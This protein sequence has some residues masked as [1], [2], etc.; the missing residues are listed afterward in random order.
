MND[1][2][3]VLEIID[4]NLY[5]K[6]KKLVDEL[7]D[8]VYPNINESLAVDYGIYTNHN[9]E[10]FDLVIEQAGHILKV[11]EILQIVYKENDIEK[12]NTEER[13]KFFFLNSLELFILLCAI[14]VHDIGLIIDRE[15]HATNILYTMSILK[16]DNIS[17]VVKQVISKIA[18]AHT[19]SKEGE[20]DTIKI[21]DKMIAIKNQYVRPQTLAAILRFS[22]ELEEGEHRTSLTNII[23]G[24]IKD[25]NIVFHKYSLSLIDLSINHNEYCLTLQ[26]E[27]EEKENKIYKKPNG[28]EVKL[29]EE[30]YN[31]LQKLEVER[32]YFHRFMCNSLSIEKI[33]SK[34][35]F[36]DEYGN[37]N[38]EILVTTMDTYPSVE[39]HGLE[40]LKKEIEAMQ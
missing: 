12:L 39:S 36:K 7:E 3:K 10:H 23:T 16:I 38:K 11:K 14:R 33:H 37:Y 22:D 25:E 34:I 24:K 31:R 27:I 26:F 13:K 9:K 15:N 28:K 20:K 29:I 1:L 32:K 19:G 18:T 2:E 35:N 5:S 8:K 30:I 6:Y 21:L 17:N 40:D 4:N